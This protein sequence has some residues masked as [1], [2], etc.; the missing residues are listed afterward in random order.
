MKRTVPVTVTCLE[1]TSPAQRAAAP[2][3]AGPA[4]V[5]R[6]ERPTLSFYR[7]LYDTVGADWNWYARRHLSGEALATIIH[8][9]RVEVFV[10]YVRGVPAGFVELDRRVEGEV[11]IAYF[12]LIPEYIGRGL[13]PF[14]LD[15]ALG[16]A[17]SYRPRRVWLH[18]CSLD[19]PKALAVYERAGFV[20]YDRE[21][22]HVDADLLGLA[23]QPSRAGSNR[24][25]PGR[26]GGRRSRPG[27][28]GR[29]GPDGAGPGR[30]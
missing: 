9:D 5:L 22:E 25:G 11:Q 14:L 4:T 23:M 26:A 12:G 18:T 15:R 7:Y 16:R 21:V 27:P 17:W 3:R 29:T 28:T 6:A 13:G 24:T 20:V 1:M 10:L 8:D 2:G 19:H 30:T